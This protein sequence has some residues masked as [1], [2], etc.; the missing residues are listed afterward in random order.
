[1]L[2]Q[3]GV[4]GLELHRFLEYLPG[5]VETALLVQRIPK[6]A[7]ILRLGILPDGARKPGDR[8]IKLPVLQQQQPHKMLG[9]R[10]LRLGR[11]HLLANDLRLEMSPRAKML[12]TGFTELVRRVCRSV[13]TSFGLFGDDSACATVHQ[14]ISK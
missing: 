6:A 13:L 9:V 8:V 11:E 5:L 4:I 12:R 1:V 3:L 10:M 7:K 14:G 2:P